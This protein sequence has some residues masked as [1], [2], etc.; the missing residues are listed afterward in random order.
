MNNKDLLNIFGEIDEDLIEDAA[1]I[2]NSEKNPK[3]RKARF[4]WTRY[5]A[6]AACCALILSGVMMS[7]SIIDKLGS[8]DIVGDSD[9][10]TTEDQ[11]TAEETIETSS[12]DYSDKETSQITTTEKETNKTTETEIKIEITTEKET[13]PSEI[14]KEY[15][16]TLGGEY[17]YCSA[18]E[19]SSNGKD[20]YKY[21]DATELGLVSI[22][23]EYSYSVDET[24]EKT[25]RYNFNKKEVELEY[26][27]SQICLTDP[28]G[29]VAKYNN[30]D[31]YKDADGGI[32]DFFTEN[33]KLRFYFSYNNQNNT[34]ITKKISKDE[35][36]QIAN[37]FIIDLYSEE[38]LKSYTM[39]AVGNNK[40]R[41]SYTK[42][43][44]G[45]RTQ[46]RIDIYINIAGTITGYRGFYVSMYDEIMKTITFDDI[47][48]AEIEL[49][50]SLHLRN[51]SIVDK[52]LEMNDKGEVCMS[53]YVLHGSEQQYYDAFYLPIT[54]SNQE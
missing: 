40:Y 6:V 2:R 25:K 18:G 17:I 22:T 43:F 9:K 3:P 28:S 30:Y 34:N 7:R 23:P 51:K 42:E 33:S 5:V 54:P 16:V 1:P 44:Y 47:E 24:K 53:L 52:V 20:G 13:I 49:E 35:A 32:Y 26:Y 12:E 38:V 29:L 8:S 41:I 10:P 4:D 39:S 48:F 46:D 15:I 45:F 50:E 19:N 11:M 37:Q 14:N 21:K 36:I 31:R 27:K